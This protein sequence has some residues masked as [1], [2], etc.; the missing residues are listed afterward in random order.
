MF[1]IDSSGQIGNS[2]CHFESF[3]LNLS[4]LLSSSVFCV[5][6]EHRWLKDLSIAPKFQVKKRGTSKRHIPVMFAYYDEGAFRE[7]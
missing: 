1:G 5:P 2:R 7:F 6:Y 4:T 3:S